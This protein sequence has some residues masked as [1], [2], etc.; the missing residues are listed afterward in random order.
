MVQMSLAGREL[1][2]KS[3]RCGPK[4]SGGVERT[5]EYHARLGEAL[6]RQVSR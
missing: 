4:N 5:D 2:W 1:S 6:D 3:F